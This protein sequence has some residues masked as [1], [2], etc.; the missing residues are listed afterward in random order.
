VADFP[1]GRGWGYDGVQLFA[2]AHCYG[3]PDDF[4]A[5]VDA[6]HGHGLAVILDVVYNHFGPDGNYLS[7]FSPYYFSHED[8][9]PWGD[10]VNFGHLES[11]P[12]RDFFKANIFYWMEEFHMDGFR[13]DATHAI[14]DQSEKHILRELAEVVHARGGYIIAEDERNHAKLVSCPEQGGYGL[15]AVWAD[16]FHHTVEVAVIE[17]SVYEK[18][19]TGELKELV[20]ALQQGWYYCGQVAPKNNKRRG[21]PCSEL[22]PERFVHC[23]ANHDQIGN[24]ALG[25]RL[26][27]L[28]S[29]ETYRAASA[30]LLLAP[31]TPLLFMGQEWAASSPFQYFTDHHGEL[32]RLVEEGRRK[33]FSAAFENVT[34]V[35][36]PQDPQ[37]FLRSKL[38]WDEVEQ[39]PYAQVLALYRELIRVRCTHDEFRPAARGTFQFAA[40]DSGVLAM[41]LEGWLFL[42]DLHGGHE[43]A[44]DHELCRPPAGA[45]WRTVLSTNEV[46]FGGSRAA[47]ATSV[48]RF[49]FPQ[50]EGLLL[51]ADTAGG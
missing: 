33:E 13:L 40:L 18:D 37:T 29:P 36:S 31:Y 34:E 11:R 38:K 2:P 32:G 16:D 26:N 8:K 14:I 44:L 48:E 12:V 24:R 9:T 51:R 35:P 7:Q 20:A 10:A 49:S 6:A 22:P 39:P 30:L 1:G 23:I 45:T 4:R 42:C 43:G 25:E 15:D 5:L 21:S 47:A 28:V 27:H 19:F 41:R 46:R 17:G 50:P 3:T